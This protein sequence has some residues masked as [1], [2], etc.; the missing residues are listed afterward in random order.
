MTQRVLDVIS[1]AV[2]F[3]VH[4]D[5]KLTEIGVDSLGMIDLFLT[6]EERFGVKFPLKVKKPPKTVRDIVEFVEAA[7]VDVPN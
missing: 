7:R 2:G 4:I 1:D 6:F 3:P 5:E